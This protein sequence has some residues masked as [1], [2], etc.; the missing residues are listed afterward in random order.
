M[1]ED[2]AEKFAALL[3]E[4]AVTGDT[5]TLQKE[6]AA[7]QLT[8]A[9]SYSPLI[10][11]GI[12]AGL[13]GLSGYLS[14]EKEKEKNRNALYGAL[15]GA[16]G[17][18]GAGL[19]YAARKTPAA[20]GALDAVDK[21]APTD[22]TTN[23]K[24]MANYLGWGRATGTAAGATAGGALGA[25][26]AG[27]RIDA[28]ADRRGWGR[29]GELDRLANAP[30]EGKKPN[31]FAGP[32]NQLISRIRHYGVGTGHDQIDKALTRGDLGGP[33]AAR[34]TLATDI[35]PLLARLA[36][37]NKKAP[38]FPAQTLLRE[39]EKHRKYTPAQRAL[40]FGARAGGGLGGGIAGGVAAGTV[41]GMLQNLIARGLSAAPK[42]E[43]T[44]PTK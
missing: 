34:T 40:R 25:R 22:L 5:G 36:P 9:A 30:G 10:G 6:A 12:G 13:G 27:R 15:I 38:P 31:Q 3:G 23:N 2:I 44:P 1:R 4:S 21:S 35:D 29:A 43:P 28:V 37:S 42:P 14:S 7:Q 8:K 26:S 41:G 17:G 24:S 32:L 20:N 19:V 33:S 39:L 11:A 18:G 16:L